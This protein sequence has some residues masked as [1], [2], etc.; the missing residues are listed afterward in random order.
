MAHHRTARGDHPSLGHA[1][2]AQVTKLRLVFGPA[3]TVPEL[4]A[5]AAAALDPFDLVPTALEYADHARRIPAP[6]ELRSSTPATPTSTV[7]W[8]GSCRV[9]GVR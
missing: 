3:A 1:P 7:C 5:A 2:D 8:P 6:G 9:A 4:L